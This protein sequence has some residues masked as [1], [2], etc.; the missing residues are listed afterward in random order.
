MSNFLIGLIEC[1]IASSVISLIYIVALPILLKRYSARWLYIIGLII[2]AGWLIIC[3]FPPLHSNQTK[4][5]VLQCIS[6]G[7]IFLRDT[8]VISTNNNS[9]ITGISLNYLLLFIWILGAVISIGYQI[10]RHWSFHKLVKRWSKTIT[11]PTILKHW[12]SL[13]HQL[14][15]DKNVDLRICPI[16]STPM[17]IGVFKPTV[18]LPANNH[19][20]NNLTLI[21]QHELFHLKYYDLWFKL[22]TLVVT[23]LHWFNPIVY[24]YAKYIALQSEIAC[25]ESIVQNAD[26]FKRKQYSQ[27]ILNYH[28]AMIAP[29][30]TLTTNFYGGKISMKKRILSIMDPK[31]KKSALI[32]LCII[33]LG[34]FGIRTAF[35]S[36]PLNNNQSHS[37]LPIVMHYLPQELPNVIGKKQTSKLIYSGDLDDWQKTYITIDYTL[38]CAT[39]ISVVIINCSVTVAGEND[40]HTPFIVTKRDINVAK[41]KISIAL[42]GYHD[43]GNNQRQ[44]QEWSFDLKLVPIIITVNDIIL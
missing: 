23:V 18:I 43:F 22:L 33:L 16:V 1:S 10:Y 34:G 36:S 44:E 6:S 7:L 28:K 8:N 25:D 14:G 19:D 20:Y 31:K 2:T 11:E 12:Y 3:P 9:S 38:S 27:S 42:A 15:I 39:D 35:S 21:L 17:L 37:V 41:D 4:I 29:R 40:L 26:S 30:T 13:K 32:L 5:P 24:L